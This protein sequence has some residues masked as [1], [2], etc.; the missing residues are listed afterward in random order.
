M[1]LVIAQCVLVVMMTDDLSYEENQ[2]YWEHTK[3]RL[4]FFFWTGEDRSKA[5]KASE[6]VMFEVGFEV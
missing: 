6:T 5:G 3:G 1:F 4:P 2:E